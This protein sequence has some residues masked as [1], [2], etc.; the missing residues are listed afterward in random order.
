M[1]HKSGFV[2]II[3]RPNV[4]KSTLMNA[5]IG[6]RMSII[7][8]KPQTTRHRIIGLLSDDDFQ[9]VFS[10]TPGIIEDPSYGMQ[11]VMNRFAHSTFEDA[12]IM[13]FV[14]APDERYEEDDPILKKLQRVEAPLFIILNK[15][16]K[17]TDEK[18]EKWI[19]LWSARFPEKTILPISA[20]RKSKTEDLLQLVLEH[21]PEGPA[22]YPKDQLTDRPE[23][24]F[25]SE[26]IREKIMQLYH[27]EIP[28]STE[29]IV[30]RFKETTT[31]NDEPL[32]RIEAM[33][34]VSRRTQ[35]PIIIGKGGSAIKKLGT[36]SRKSIETFLEKKVFLELFVKIR[37]NWRD[38]ERQLKHFGY[39]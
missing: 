27:Q 32:A 8:N 12:D 17:L 3:G 6:E 14:T 37:D 26:I 24:F 9:I 19:A 1:A 28:Y 29:V 13:L 18:L 2:N 25:V 7:T 10:D 34:Y 36:E 31:K 16:D 21:L 39:Q 5:L 15:I 33:I 35:K 4:G 11:K 22:Y 20:L 30:E 38:D 23:R